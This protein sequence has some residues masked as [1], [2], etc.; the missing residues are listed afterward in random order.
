MVFSL[1]QA[2]LLTWQILCLLIN[3]Q[4]LLYR[5]LSEI[6]RVKHTVILFSPSFDREDVT[7]VTSYKQA[8]EIIICWRDI[9]QEV[10]VKFEPQQPQQLVSNGGD[11]D[12]MSWPKVSG[13]SWFH[14]F[15]CFHVFCI[16]WHLYSVFLF[17]CSSILNSHW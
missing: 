13:S 3:L 8:S 12:S 15:S 1:V 17:L 14:L 7:N 9:S 2:P 11:Q 6:L 5:V 16:H 10:V 4:G